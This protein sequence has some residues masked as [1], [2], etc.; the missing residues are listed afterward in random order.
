MY[1]IF[2]SE[3]YAASHGKETIVYGALVRNT[4]EYHIL[5]LA[6]ATGDIR[7]LVAECHYL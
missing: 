5:L 7:R 4:A 1:A 2:L 3:Q 6:T